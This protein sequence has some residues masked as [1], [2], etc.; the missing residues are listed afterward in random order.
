MALL[1]AG[2][3]SVP[4]AARPT[5]NSSTLHAHN[6]IAHVTAQSGPRSPSTSVPDSVR[7]LASASPMP[8]NARLR[9]FEVIGI[10]YALSSLHSWL[11]H[12]FETEVADTLGIRPNKWG[13]LDTYQEAHT[14]LAWMM[15][16]P[17]DRA[18]EPVYWTVAAITECDRQ[19]P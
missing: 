5:W 10:E 7:L 6:L 15:D 4:R 3:L 14:V 11:C 17:A 16:L 12:S 2:Y 1:V 13:P 9:G 18:P 8:P 19:S